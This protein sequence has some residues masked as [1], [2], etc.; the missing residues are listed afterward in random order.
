MI[1]KSRAA[2]DDML[3]HYFQSVCHGGIDFQLEFL[4]K[5]VEKNNT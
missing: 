5:K 1:K 2:G 3:N 4:F